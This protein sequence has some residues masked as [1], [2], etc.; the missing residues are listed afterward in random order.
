MNIT[1]SGPWLHTILFEIPVLAIV[2]ELYFQDKEND[3]VIAE[4]RERLHAKIA[5]LK[6][7]EL[8]N[9]KIEIGRAHV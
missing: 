2:N 9:L 6:S 7:P 8:T 3:S 1:I 5:K 4:G